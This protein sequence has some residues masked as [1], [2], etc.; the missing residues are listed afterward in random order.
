M[1][2]S[3]IIENIE[4]KSIII[5]VIGIGRIGLPTALC[6]AKAGFETIGVDINE[7]LVNMINSKD[8][9]L[10]D[11]PEFDKI[12][13]TVISKQKLSATTNINDAIPECDII[14]LSLPTPMD[15]QNIPDYNAL[16][17]V[18]ASLNKLL[19][20]GQIV[21]VES[22][23]EPGFR[24]PGP[25][26]TGKPGHHVAQNIRSGPKGAQGVLRFVAL[27]IYVWFSLKSFALF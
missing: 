3:K 21:I 27:G 6:F 26:S 5:S 2:N 15:N 22:T 23:V 19:S 18:G 25:Q 20:N 24:S 9:P 7:K 14:I 8:Y 16:L 17:T 10:K 12:F 11:E 13:D 1:E 4:N